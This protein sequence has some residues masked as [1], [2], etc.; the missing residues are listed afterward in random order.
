LKLRNR[1]CKSREKEVVQGKW[2]FKIILTHN[3]KTKNLDFLWWKRLDTIWDRADQKWKESEDNWK[4]QNILR[5]KS[6]Q[7]LKEMIT[8]KRKYKVTIQSH[9]VG[10][11][12]SFETELIGK[13]KTSKARI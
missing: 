12:E 6:N 8:M 1:K 3:T 4:D 7:I 10:L 9:Q 2:L 11:S 13:L 5:L